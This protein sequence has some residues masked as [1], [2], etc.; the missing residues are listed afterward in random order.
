MQKT[1]VLTNE[2]LKRFYNSMLKESVSI[3][4]SI[5]LQVKNF[6]DKEGFRP[7]FYDDIDDDGNAVK[8]V[9]INALGKVSKQPIQKHTKEKMIDLMDANQKLHE[10]IKDDNDRREAFEDI[11]SHW[12]NGTIGWDG[13]LKN[14]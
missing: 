1:V 13:M 5:V 14:K 3:K 6:L 12:I 7:E 9:C 8:R 10:L 11:L 4:P 2:Q